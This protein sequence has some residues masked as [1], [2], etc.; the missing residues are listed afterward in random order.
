MHGRTCMSPCYF[1]RA[2]EQRMLNLNVC[3]RTMQLL[4]VCLASNMAWFAHAAAALPSPSPAWRLDGHG[5]PTRDL[6]QPAQAQL[7]ATTAASA[8]AVDDPAI[9]WQINSPAGYPFD[10]A[11]LGNSDIVV[12]AQDCNFTFGQWRVNGSYIWQSYD[13]RGHSGCADG[14]LTDVTTYYTTQARRAQL[15]HLVVVTASFH[16]VGLYPG[17]AWSANIVRQDSAGNVK[18]FVDFGSFSNINV[19]RPLLL[20][21]DGSLLAFL[22]ANCSDGFDERSASFFMIDAENGSVLWSHHIP[23]LPYRVHLSATRASAVG[24]VAAVV[25]SESVSF[26]D[27]LNGKSVAQQLQLPTLTHATALSSDST[28]FAA[29]HNASVTLYQFSSAHAAYIQTATLPLSASYPTPEGVT[30]VPNGLI[31]AASGSL[32]LLI[33]GAAASPNYQIVTLDAWS[34]PL[35]AIPESSPLPTS[36]QQK[37][38]WSF[39]CDTPSRQQLQESFTTFDLV[40]SDSVL[41]VG[42]WGAGY[43]LFGN[44]RPT[45]RALCTVSGKVAASFVS[46]GSVM[47][48]SAVDDDSGGFSVAV[49]A[50]HTHANTVVPG[51]DFY[52]LKYNASTVAA[53]H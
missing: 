27:S 2:V 17:T 23:D 32:T 11:A 38:L 42:S 25:A 34:L 39:A 31:F 13:H 46:D 47:D 52:M 36:Q 53:C 51:G 19:K 14:T 3:N 10:Q 8:P 44:D 28:Y 35:P 48:L 16:S 29:S 20:S 49:A 24:R 7:G 33:A 5:V 26:F 30:W 15:Q 40:L 9:S 6:Q 1:G 37:P 45:A 43:G 18:W 4:V 22:A 50:K 41:V 12:G 21:D